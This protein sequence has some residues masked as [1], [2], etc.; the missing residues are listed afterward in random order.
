MHAHTQTKDIYYYHHHSGEEEEE[1]YIRMYFTRIW[2]WQGEG[3]NIEW[4][5]VYKRNGY[6]IISKLGKLNEFQDG[7][8]NW[9]V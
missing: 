7:I 6:E 5:D 9:Y 1:R 8:Q 3:K 4:N 2:G